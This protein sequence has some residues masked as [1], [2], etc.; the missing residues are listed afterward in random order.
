MSVIKVKKT[1]QYTHRDFRPFAVQAKDVLMIS[2]IFDGASVQLE[3][4]NNTHLLTE[5]KG[6]INA[7]ALRKEIRTQLLSQ[8]VCR[9]AKL[10]NGGVINVSRLVSVSMEKE[11]YLMTDPRIVL[12][13]VFDEGTEH[14]LFYKTEELCM[15]RFDSLTSEMDKVAT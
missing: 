5:V 11:P 1:D 7:A 6:T 15:D 12:T 13:V 9:F 2:P 14:S 8:A 4:I 3:T 10:D